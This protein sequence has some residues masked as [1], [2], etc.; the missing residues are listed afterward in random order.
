[1]A[2]PQEAIKARRD[3]RR[4]IKRAHIV[5]H[6][7]M[8]QVA[9]GDLREVDRQSAERRALLSIRAANDL[10]RSLERVNEALESKET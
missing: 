1:M 3:L 7:C 6:R 4:Q 5:A 10:E 2:N 8:A 9:D